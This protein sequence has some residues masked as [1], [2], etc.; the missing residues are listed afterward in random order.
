MEKKLKFLLR[1]AKEKELYLLYNQFKQ[2]ITDFDKFVFKKIKKSKEFKNF[3][4]EI[5]E[6]EQPRLFESDALV[7]TAGRLFLKKTL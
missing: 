7:N 6:S 3:L 4:L 1:E 2:N 5:E